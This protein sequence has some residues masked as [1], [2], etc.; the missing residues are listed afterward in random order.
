MIDSKKY[1]I[2]S[3][4]LED[5]AVK[6]F[7][8]TEIFQKYIQSILNEGITVF[9]FDAEKWTS[10]DIFYSELSGK[11]NFPHYFGKNLDALNDCLSEMC[12]E[13]FAICILN[14]EFFWNTYPREAKILLELIQ[15][16]CWHS[17][18]IDSVMLALIQVNIPDFIPPKLEIFSAYWNKME[19]SNKSRGL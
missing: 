7:Y 6:F 14:Y 15:S 12:G 8:K 19:W 4:L 11:M 10:V 17:L 3:E 5:S 18:K 13:K 2:T 16:N 9:S 1:Q